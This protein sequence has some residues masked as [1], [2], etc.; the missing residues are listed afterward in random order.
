MFDINILI[1]LNQSINEWLNVIKDYINKFDQ[2]GLYILGDEWNVIHKKIKNITTLCDITKSINYT[3]F[4][5]FIDILDYNFTEI[6]KI[7]PLLLD[8]KLVNYIELNEKIDYKLFLTKTIEKILYTKIEIN[9]YIKKIINNFE[10]YDKHFLSKNS[11]EEII[12]IY[13]STMPHNN[14]ITSL[15]MYILKNHGKI[16]LL[17]PYKNMILCVNN[18]NYNLFEH[19]IINPIQKINYLINPFN[20]IN[21]HKKGINISISNQT[22]EYNIFPL[23]SNTDAIKFGPISSVNTGINKQLI[24][25][26]NTIKLKD[27]ILTNSIPIDNTIGPLLIY[28]GSDY[29]SITPINFR[30]NHEWY[31]MKGTN[32][33]TYKY[34]ELL[35]DSI[36]NNMKI[37]NSLYKSFKSKKISPIVSNDILFKN[38]KNISEI[39]YNE[40]ES[41]LDRKLVD[42]DINISR[43]L[44]L[45]QFFN[46]NKIIESIRKR[47]SD[48]IEIIPIVRLL[49]V[50]KLI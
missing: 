20:T 40:L 39:C 35:Q 23:I 13:D 16:N 9:D 38:T 30:E 36:I 34:N 14:I 41:F 12:F 10:S 27:N 4:I 15:H 25:R 18:N 46:I 43:E 3:E 8:N 45:L 49:S 21:E 33:R 7:V 48:S 44:Y 31:P 17:E 19:S 24:N 28:T 11:L 5:K 32:A 47:D 22:V 37:D 50:I 1:S 42:K 26:F 29:K 6:S 2:I